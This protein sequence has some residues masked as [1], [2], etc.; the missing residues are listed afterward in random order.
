MRRNGRAR[1]RARAGVVG[2]TLLLGLV[3][4]G[5]S[6]AQPAIYPHCSADDMPAKNGDAQPKAPQGGCQH[7][8]G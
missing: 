7:P 2:L 6:T 5:C 1:A 8:P 3:L 4:S